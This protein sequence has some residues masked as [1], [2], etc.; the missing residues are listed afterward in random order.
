[1]R[2]Q[3]AR[4]WKE[5]ECLKRVMRGLP[6][7]TSQSIKSEPKQRKVRVSGPVEPVE[8]V[9][10]IKVSVSPTIEPAPVSQAASQPDCQPAKTTGAWA[11]AM[12]EPEP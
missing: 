9:E 12:G 3:A 1:V 10:P 11:K 8:V 2:A 7:N 5:I 6:A 4:A